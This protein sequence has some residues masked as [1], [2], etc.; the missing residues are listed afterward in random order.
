MGTTRSLVPAGFPLP[1]RGHDP[2]REYPLDDLIAWVAAWRGEPFHGLR[3]VCPEC[4]NQADGRGCWTLHDLATW[5]GFKF[6]YIRSRWV[7]GALTEPE[8]DWVA[9]ALGV[10]PANIWPDLYA[11]L[12]PSG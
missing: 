8:A 3:P 1:R 11:E 12:A 10:H 9:V 6:H 5:T 4:S 2:R 7:D